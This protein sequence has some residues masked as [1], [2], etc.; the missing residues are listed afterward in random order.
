LVGRIRRDLRKRGI[1]IADQTKV[2]R[3]LMASDVRDLLRADRLNDAEH[4]AAAL[5][6]T[7]VH[8]PG[9]VALVGAGPGDPDLLTVKARELI[10]D[11]NYVLHDALISDETLSLCGPNAKLEAVGKRGGAE[12]TNQMHINARLIELAGAG[13]FVV[14]LKGGDPFVFGRGGEELNALTAAGIDVIVVPGITSAFAA[15]AAAGIP[16]TMRGFSSSIAIVTAQ[17]GEGIDRIR[18]LARVSETLIVLMARSNLEEVASAIAHTVGRGRLAALVS[19]ATLPN[20]RSVSGPIADIARLA[21]REQIE[22][23]ATLIVGDVVGAGQTLAR[24]VIAS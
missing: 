3:R 12:S 14:R 4:R 8:H 9:R 10:A 22:T 7:T 1:S 15:P 11:A 21:D 24:L 17:G 23:P 19:N 6:Q 5:A 13:H 2:Y 20:Q 16:A 18:E